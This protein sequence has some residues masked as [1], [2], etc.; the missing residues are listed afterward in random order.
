MSRVSLVSAA[1]MAGVLLTSGC[2]RGSTGAPDAPSRESTTSASTQQ[3]GST[4]LTAAQVFRRGELRGYASRDGRETLTVWEVC[5]DGCRHHWVLSGGARAAIVGDA[6]RRAIPAVT[7]GR[8]GY[9]VKAFGRPGFVVRP[10]GTTLALREGTGP[11]RIHADTVILPP[12]RGRLTAVNPARGTSW[13][14]PALPGRTSIY[15]TAVSGGGTVWAIP[16]EQGTDLTLRRL[17][18]GQWR[19]ISMS[20]HYPADAT[21]QGI[22]TTTRAPT[23]IAVAA[24][25]G[26][27]VTPPT[28][29]LV[30]TDAG[31]TWH[32]LTDHELPFRLA[33]SMA[34][35]G[36]TLYLAGAGG[37][38]WRTVD[39]SWT[40]L[41][42][43]PRL[44]GATGL[45]PAGGRVIAWRWRRSELVSIDRAGRV[46]VIASKRRSPNG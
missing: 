27:A 39:R 38:V 20:G 43:V 25:Y 17:R 16:H 1:V 5:A 22:V 3:A 42:R 35:A 23:R 2:G 12:R 13:Q 41:E 6:G 15:Q 19:S 9:V 24:T 36:D 7:A 44:R 37:R 46:D 18:G 14:L 33:D 10:D 31:R 26:R 11:Q 8:K 34:V 30:S 28:L 21:Q 29:L 4:P 32:R 40:R 45:Q